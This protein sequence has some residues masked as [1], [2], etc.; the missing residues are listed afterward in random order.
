[1]DWLVYIFIESTLTLGVLLAL[2]CFCLLVYW[3]REGRP[4]PLLIGL[5]VSALLLI[6]QTAVTTQREHAWRILARIERDVLA[7]ET[8]RLAASLSDDFSAA[9]YDKPRFIELVDGRYDVV[10]VIWLRR[11]SCTIVEST[12]DSFTAEVGYLGEVRA[13][14]YMTAIDSKWRIKFI[15]RERDW[16]IQTV[17]PLSPFTSWDQVAG[18][19]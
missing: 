4:R 12:A 10:S 19:R 5:A 6:V 16:K 11:L 1:M 13:S 3:R 18:Y 8:D 14:E 15:R 9:R 17:K 7:G 2:V